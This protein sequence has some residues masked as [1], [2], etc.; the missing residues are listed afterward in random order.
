MKL[1]ITGVSHKTAPVEVRE[2]LAFRPETLPAALADL[3]A[4]EG[5]VEAVILSTCNRVEITVTADDRSDPRAIVDSFLADQKAISASAIAPHLYRHEGQD[6]IH[7]LFRVAASLDSMVVGEPQILGQLKAAYA[8]AKE[9]GALCGWLDGLMTR[10]FGVAKRV[11]S[12]TGVGQMAVS[13]SYAAVEL[14]RKI[15]GSLVN[16][17]IMIVGAGKMSELAARHLRRSGASHVFVTNRTHERAVEMAALFQGTPVE[18][19]RFVSMLPEVDIV[20]ASSGAPHYILRKEEMQRVISARRNKPMFLIDIAVPRNIEPSVNDV[21][22]VYLYDIDDLQEVVN[23]NLRERMKEAGHAEAMVTEEVDRMMA[24]LKV[25][26]VTPTIVGLQE[27]LEQIRAAELDKMRHKCGPLTPEME[28]AIEAM[29]RAIMN[30]V[31]H[32]PISELR[33]QAGHPEG[34]HVV[35][36]IRKAFH[37]QDQ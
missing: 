36:A 30:K 3:K 7:H 29:T 32:G 13:V 37:L 14:A 34:A 11:R 33:N 6:A 20:I 5:V 15:F 31:A 8:A 22:N 2:C 25:A 17:T 26:E 24:R 23:A 19:T 1:H 27:Q 4:R 12:E 16:R 9:C 18:Y 10:A 21:D 28:Q 35:A